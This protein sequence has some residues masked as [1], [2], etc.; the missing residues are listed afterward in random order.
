MTLYTETMGDEGVVREMNELICFSAN[1][2]EDAGRALLERYKLQTVPAILITGIDGE[3][4]EML[5]GFMD[6]ATFVN[7]IQRIKRGENTIS[8]LRAKI[9]GEHEELE[10]ELEERQMLAVKLGNIGEAEEAEALRQSILERDPKSTTVLGSQAHVERILNEIH[11][12]SGDE[13]SEWDFK[14]LQ[15]YATR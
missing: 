14:P 15:K 11:E 2:G 9:A 12:K 5:V 4:E 1:A 10:T 6:P 7:E 13:L 8:D 3:A